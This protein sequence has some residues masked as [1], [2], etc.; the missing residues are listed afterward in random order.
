M[1]RSGSCKGFVYI[2]VGFTKN[3]VTS[4]NVQIQRFPGNNRPFFV[5]CIDSIIAQ[6]ICRKKLV[7]IGVIYHQVDSKGILYS[8]YPGVAIT[9]FYHSV[10][11]FSGVDTI[12]VIIF[13]DTN[14]RKPCTWCNTIRVLV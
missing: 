12:T 11:A 9:V 6:Q 7:S 2:W 8:G 4:K 1:H 14:F 5:N 13:I 3:N 10:N